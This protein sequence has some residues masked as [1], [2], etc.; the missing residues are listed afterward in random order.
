MRTFQQWISEY[1]KSHQNPTNKLIHNICVPLITF[2]VVGLLWSLPFP[3]NSYSFN[4]GIIFVIAS[5]VFYF[6]MNFKI[7]LGLL[8]Q[9]LLIFFLCSFFNKARVL[10]PLSVIVFVLAWIGQFYGHKI[11]GKKPSFLTD[12][13]FLLVGPMWVTKALFDKFGVRL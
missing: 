12:L 2:S 11:E 7:F 13:V 10:L 6:S 3:E 8:V 1:G 4:W 9:A 5:L